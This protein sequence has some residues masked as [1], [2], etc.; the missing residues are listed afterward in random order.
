LFDE[1]AFFSATLRLSKDTKSLIVINKKLLPHKKYVGTTDPKEVIVTT[2]DYNN[3]KNE[4][5]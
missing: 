3:G 4:V 1:T 5:Q 2:T